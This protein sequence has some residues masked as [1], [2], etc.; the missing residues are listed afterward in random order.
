MEKG[1]LAI[2]ATTLASI[3]L[4]AENLIEVSV[5]AG[6]ASSPLSP[7]THQCDGG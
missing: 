1:E 5:M 4:S 7:Q 3:E 2:P 6:I